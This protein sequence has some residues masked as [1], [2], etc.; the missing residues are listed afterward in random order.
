MSQPPNILV[1][2]TDQQRADHLGC[3]GH[4]I[5]QTPHLDNLAARGIRFTNCFTTYPACMPARGTMMTGLTHRASGMRSNGVGL[6]PDIPTLP[7]LLAA[8]GYRTHAIGKL[9]LR[10]WHPPRS[11]DISEWETPDQNPERIQHWENGLITR[12]PDDYHGFQTT[13]LTIGHVT[14]VQGDYRTWLDET[15][16]DEVAHYHSRKPS[17]PSKS[18]GP[19]PAWKLE[20]SPPSHYNEWIA[21]RSIEFLRDSDRNQPFFLWSSFPD[22]HEPFAAIA[23][24]AEAYEAVEIA[25][26]DWA[27]E[28]RNVP[29]TLFAARGGEAAYRDRAEK[30]SASMRDYYVQTFGMISHVD[31]QIGRVVEE[32]ITLGLWENTLVAFLSDHGDELGQHGLMH[33][34]YWPYDG[35]AR[36]PFILSG[37]P[38]E[39]P[40]RTVEDV[41][42]LLDLVPTL[43]DVAGVTQ[44]EDPQVNDAYRTQAGQLPTSLPGESLRQLITDP[45]A[46]PIR[47]SAL[48]ETDDELNPNFD[49]L[50]MRVLVTNDYKLCHYSPTNEVILYDRRTDPLERHNLA[51]DP[52]H[53]GTVVRLLAQLVTEINRTENRRPRRF[54][55]A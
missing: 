53:H 35:N 50:Q 17:D 23:R 54:S 36:V 4:S 11:F 24:W 43:L 7:G 12:S 32:L 16:P 1:F 30:F 10:P 25:I 49:L 5:L 2:C 9:H 42:S 6:N 22:P 15:H 40:G 48:I 26:P 14:D 45:D 28:L 51:A 21:D 20:A 13:D 19:P 34:G 46:R 39:T 27:E 8:S 31:E 44:P 18:T 52:A 33:K 37:G 38:I 47:R 29:E 55:D 3:A 41:V